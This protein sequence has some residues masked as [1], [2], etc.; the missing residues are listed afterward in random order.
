[1]KRTVITILSL[2]VSFLSFSQQDLKEGILT[3]KQTM[4]SKNEQMNAQLSRMGNITTTTYIKND[5]S[6]SEFTSPMSGETKV[7]I[8]GTSKELLL[9]MNT[10][11]GKMYTKESL[12]IT[13]N[14]KDKLNVKK[15]DK[16]KTIM[17]YECQQFL[18]K[19]TR[20]GISVDMELYTTDKIKG[21]MQDSA[22]FGDLIEGFPLY[23]V[24]KMNVPQM[25]GEVTIINEVTEIKKESVADDK[26]DMTVPDGYKEMPKQQF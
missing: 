1:M 6:Y 2:V 14:D 13:D 18:A 25:G 3:S 5:K 17:G 19:T 9:L 22:E 26:F 15:G 11:G 16:V 24:M 8:D 23:T 4:S 21:Y 20:R 12:E 10:G 7:I